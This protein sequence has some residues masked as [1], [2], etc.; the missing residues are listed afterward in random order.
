MNMEKADDSIAR[1]CD[2]AQDHN[3]YDE[4]GKYSYEDFTNI[5]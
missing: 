2:K 5:H 4:D 3:S 1:E